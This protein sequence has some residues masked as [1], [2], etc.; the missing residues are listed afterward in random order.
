MNAA[1]AQG[2]GRAPAA[3]AAFRL[4]ILF[5]GVF[6][7]LAVATIALAI[8]L[9]QDEKDRSYRDYHLSLSRTHADVLAKLR[10]PAGLLALLNPGPYRVPPLTP[11]V[12][13]YATLDFQDQNSVH[14]LVDQAGCSVHYPDGSTLCAAVGGTEKAAGFLYL[15]GG[16]FAANLVGR[17][18]AGEPNTA[19]R[20]VIRVESGKEQQSWVAPFE[21]LPGPDDILVRGRIAAF[22]T[23]EAAAAW[24]SHP[25]R[26]FRGG[27]WQSASCAGSGALPT[28]PR[29]VFYAMRVPVK[30]LRE[31]GGA[32]SRAAWPPDDLDRMHVH[33]A[34]L[35]P[36]EGA[37]LFD[38]DAQGAQPP[39][40]LAEPVQ[41]LKPGEALT[42][43]RLDLPE[44]NAIVLK[45]REPRAEP[46]SP[47]LLRLVSELPVAS[48]SKRIVL[49]DTLV[50]PVGSYEVRL[51]GDASS[52]DSA[53]GSV[54]TRISWYV[55]AM[56]AAIV[57]AWL[58]IEVGLIRRIT[59]LSRRAAALSRDA[60]G[61]NRIGQLEVADLRGPDELGILAGGLADLLQRVKDDLERE[62][63]RARRERE[64][65][66]AVGHEILSPLQSLMVLFPDPG[67]PAYRYVQR[68]RQAVAALYGQASPREA[69][70]A[71]QL[72]L[73]PLDLDEFLF[74]VASNA[75]FAG[76]EGVEYRRVGRVVVQADEFSLEDV[77]AHILRNADRHRVPGTPIAMA[78]ETR[79]KR[80]VVRIHNIGSS[81]DEALLD[82]MF[83]YGVR[84]ADGDAEGAEP[85]ARR[86]QGLFVARTY[87]SKM[88]GA[89]NARN[90][91][92]GVAFRLELPLAMGGA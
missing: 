62:E 77:V 58:V 71:A 91:E 40:A 75:A 45:G 33:V 65:L 6:L 46:G 42:V 74:H 28:C 59:V 34:I 10:Q 13:P 3:V 17:D 68:M 25:V 30:S 16:F 53:L 19:H 43:V 48:P 81:V 41:S 57:L 8:V 12:L 61:G 15:V 24:Q 22:D 37:P 38:S 83:E 85:H 32:R 52:I 21:G 39:E 50:T 69:L 35:G 49:R 76:I 87:M 1:A 82:R 72:E 11:L 18:A 9:L 56:L 44:S 14:Q 86:G 67:G 66:E 29:R 31:R 70:Q 54:A 92:G 64:M 4:R 79:G 5:R 90:E 20:I 7:L 26:D 63:M 84:D 23:S 89:V 60:R 55:S 27:L 51:A 73:E 2:G 88:R 80:A 78:L 47:W 36:G